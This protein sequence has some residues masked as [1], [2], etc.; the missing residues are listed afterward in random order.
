MSTSTSRGWKDNLLKSGVPLEYEVAGLLAKHGMIVEADFAFIR[1]DGNISK[2]LSVDIVSSFYG[3]GNN[4]VGYKIS[5]I[6]ECKYRSPEKKILFVQDP[7]PE[8]YSG[9]M[10]PT[11]FFF[12]RAV[13]YKLDPSF[14]DTIDENV[15]LVYKG[16]EIFDAGAVEEELR[17][18][19]QQL[20]YASPLVLRRDLDDNLYGH[21]DDILSLFLVS[22]LVT[23]API[24][25]LKKG[26]RIDQ[27]KSAKK[28]EDIS[29]SA[30]FVILYSDAGPDF[31][32]HFKA[33]FA[34]D[35]EERLLAAK[36]IR[37]RLHIAGKNL[38]FEPD[39]VEAVEALSS[40]RRYPWHSVGTQFYVANLDG[41]RRLIP[42][43]KAAC[44]GAYGKR[45][46]ARPRLKGR[47]R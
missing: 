38:G 7:N 42:A 28:I 44:R 24:I 15:E 3:P 12:D 19:I 23:N 47:R 9:V 5:L 1:R 6:I 33:T 18:G 8:E 32:D 37:K 35:Q 25:V 36:D 34:D 40:G 16:I 39:L 4:K 31:S 29:K 17:R 30:D 11:I 26:L 14:I 2:E 10:G 20:R 22:I 27:I 43:I 46:K 13:P 41:L 21:K 45:K